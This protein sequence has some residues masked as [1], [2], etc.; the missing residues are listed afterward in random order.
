MLAAG[1]GLRLG[2][3]WQ[4]KPK[5]L[6]EYGGKTLLERHV[7][8]LQGLGIDELVMGVGFR[9]ELIRAD[10]ERIGAAGYV[11]TID[12]PEYEQ[13]PIRTMW[14]LRDAY[15]C[16]EPVL[17]MDADVL[18]D[19][20][21]MKRLIDAPAANCFALDRRIGDGEDPVRLCISNGVLVEIHKRPRLAYDNCGEWVGFAKFSPAIGTRIGPATE[22][23]LTKDTSKMI[24]EEVYRD[25]ILESPPGT[26]AVEDITGL[27]WIEID[28]P[29]DLA[30]AERDI[31]TRLEETGP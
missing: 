3:H 20:R 6:L 12:N 9:S 2:E 7:E 11:R 22:R 5:V 4:D 24:Y 30:R 10:I 19:R 23:Y 26:F 14:V 1:M 8:I 16:G 25:L 27:P 17:H 31:L 29:E 18:Y 15:G 21:L 13:G 28:F